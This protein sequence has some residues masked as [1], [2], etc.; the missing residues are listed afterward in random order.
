[1]QSRAWRV[2]CAC[3]VAGAWL[4]AS[5]GA[6]EPAKKNIEPALQEQIA[7]DR[8][9]QASQKRV[10][11][12]ADATRDLLQ[13]YRNYLSEKQSLDEYT[14]QLAVQVSSQRDEIEFVQK[15]LVDI[16]TTQREVMP[17]MQRM[18]ETLVQFVELDLPFQIEERHKRVRGLQDMMG[19]ADVTVSEKYRRIVE[20][21]QIETEYGR[22]IE[23]YEG[24]LAGTPPRTV[25]FLRLGRIA[26]L[27][28]TLDGEETGY[29]DAEKKQ[30][31]VDGSYRDAV[32]KGFA[33]ADKAGA[34]DLLEAPVPAP[35]DTKS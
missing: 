14:K 10:D 32:R 25:R 29:W 19:K 1:M 8:D 30:W 5:A 6:E 22:T 11:E 26:L 28:Q 9:A 31:V 27:Y 4:P 35:K 3:L 33:V 24:E 34:P 17:L 13:Q 18:L 21:Y 20:A 2:A 7:T 23:A 16:E 15:Q 12:T